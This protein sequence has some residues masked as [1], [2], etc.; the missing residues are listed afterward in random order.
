VPKHN[1]EF[2]RLKASLC[3][4]FSD[5]RRLII[6][7]ELRTGEKTVTDLTRA[8]SVPQASV[9][10]HLALLRERGVVQTR[11]SGINIYYR[12]TSPKICEACDIVQDIL[13]QQIENN[14]TLSKRM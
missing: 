10:R 2:Y 9:S 4:T 14:R 1:L 5:P 6:I 13:L 11:R 7:E 3:K 12:L 8:L